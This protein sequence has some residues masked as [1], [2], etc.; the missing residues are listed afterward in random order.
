MKKP[1]QITLKAKV[2]FACGGRRIELDVD[3]ENY[4]ASGW[5]ISNNSELQKKFKLDDPEEITITI[6]RKEK[7]R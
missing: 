6:K 1:K 7:A 4:S 2:G 5:F 3:Q